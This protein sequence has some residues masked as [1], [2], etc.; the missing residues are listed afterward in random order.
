L[1]STA[2]TRTTP[3]GTVTSREPI[4]AVFSPNGRWI[5][6]TSTPHDDVSAANRGVFV[7]PFPPTGTVFQVPRQLVDF[8]PLWTAD[9]RE[10]VFLAS[11][12]ARQMA[13]VRVTAN[14]GLTFGTP[15][16]FPASVTGDR[17]SAEPRSFDLL[18]DGRLIGVVTR[19]DAGR[20]L[21]SEL[22]VVLNWQEELK[23]RVRVP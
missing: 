13:A 15:T 18:P 5:A 6:Y 14:G 11:T 23:Q 20:S 2:D 1:L 3:F 4:G 22:R 21:Y 10:I 7:Q 9:G 19:T 17:L 16:R 12:N 8:H